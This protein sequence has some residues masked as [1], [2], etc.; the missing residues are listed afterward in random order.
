MSKKPSHVLHAFQKKTNR[1][2]QK[3]A[4][5]IKKRYGDVQGAIKQARKDRKS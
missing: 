4:D 1:T 3:D 5:L 2:S